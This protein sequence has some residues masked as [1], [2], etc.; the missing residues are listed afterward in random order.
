MLLRM[1][2][3]DSILKIYHPDSKAGGEG[4]S[5]PA[6]AP[7]LLPFFFFFFAFY[8]ISYLLNFSMAHQSLQIH[9]PFISG[10][11]IRLGCN[12]FFNKVF[13]RQ[14]GGQH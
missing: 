9:T 11:H 2:E 3:E 6:V 4:I 12:Q 7:L 8:L 13:H 1:I 14:P 10:P 5:Q